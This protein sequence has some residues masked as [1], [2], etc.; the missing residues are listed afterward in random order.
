MGHALASKGEKG[1]VSIGTILTYKIS[2]KT[3]HPEKNAS[4]I[5]LVSR[6]PVSRTEDQVLFGFYPL[7]FG[8]V[9]GAVG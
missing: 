4:L 6:T 3:Q 9:G 5:I 7:F 1:P 2:I 8:A